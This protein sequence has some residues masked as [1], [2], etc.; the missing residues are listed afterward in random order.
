MP[1]TGELTSASHIAATM[2][3]RRCPICCGASKTW[4]KGEPGDLPEGG[5]LLTA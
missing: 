2:V 4:L 3:R 5:E 1:G